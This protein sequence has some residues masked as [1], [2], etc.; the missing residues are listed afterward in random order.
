MHRFTP[1]RIHPTFIIGFLRIVAAFSVGNITNA[2][3]C[4]LAVTLLS[5]YGL[6]C[7]DDFPPILFSFAHLGD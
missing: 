4:S 2:R 6:D 1:R 7:S 5:C 3:F